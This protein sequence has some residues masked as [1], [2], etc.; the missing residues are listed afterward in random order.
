VG[1]RFFVLFL[2]VPRP[3]ILST[4]A[5]LSVTG[6]YLSTGSLFGIGIVLA[7]GGLGYLLR[8]LEFPFVV[9]LIGFV[10]GPIFERALRNTVNLFDDPWQLATRHPLLPVFLALGMYAVWRSAAAK[11]RSGAMTR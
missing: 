3:L 10:L 5:L 1:L 2:A 8:K 6:A 9:F 4:A 11:P 7:F